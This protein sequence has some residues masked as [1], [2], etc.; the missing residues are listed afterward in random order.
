MV[1][2]FV[3]SANG[4]GGSIC[5]QLHTASGHIFILLVA[6]SASAII[7]I[8]PNE[9]GLLGRARLA[10]W[11]GGMWAAVGLSLAVWLLGLVVV[12]V[13]IVY[14]FAFV[15]AEYLLV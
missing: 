12:F 15:A 14:I 7:Y 6:T 4:I 2:P 10:Y 13:H 9:H 11:W 5:R 3:I 8:T 1:S